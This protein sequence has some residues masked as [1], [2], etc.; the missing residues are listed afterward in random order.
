MYIQLVLIGSLSLVAGLCVG[1]EFNTTECEKRCRIEVRISIIV[2]FQHSDVLQHAISV[3]YHTRFA[4]DSS[5]ELIKC[6]LCV[7]K[8]ISLISSKSRYFGGSLVRVLGFMN[9]L[10]DRA[11]K[12]IRAETYLV[13]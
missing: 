9:Y 6:K 11:Y 5:M 1:L 13:A 3:F 8:C 10:R 12:D 4:L 2:V 7:I